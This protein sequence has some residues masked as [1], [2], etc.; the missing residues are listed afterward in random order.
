MTGSLMPRLAAPTQV[1]ALEARQAGHIRH[2]K[3]WP[4]LGK[5]LERAA[6]RRP[7]RGQR[8]ARQTGRQQ[9]GGHQVQLRHIHDLVQ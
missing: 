2:G 1:Q 7:R 6:V 4:L 9:A 5:R 8:A 3:A